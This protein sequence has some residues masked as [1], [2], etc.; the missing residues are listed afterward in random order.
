VTTEAQ[1]RALVGT[2]DKVERTFSPSRKKPTGRTLTYRC[3]PHCATW[4]SINNSTGK[5]SDFESTSPGFVTER[6]SRV[7]MTA[8]EAARRENRKPRPGCGTGPYL[9]IRT[10]PHLIFVLSVWGGTVHT[11]TYLGPRSVY[12][13]GLC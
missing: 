8:K 13:E 9:Y 3:G 2:P 4:Y 6:G 11:M 7:G 5:L 12:Y 1:I 10:G